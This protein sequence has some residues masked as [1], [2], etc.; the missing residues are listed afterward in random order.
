M[1]MKTSLTRRNLS[2]P[3]LT[4]HFATYFVALTF[5]ISVTILHEM[6]CASLL[7]KQYHQQQD[8]TMDDEGLLLSLHAMN[9]N[10]ELPV[11]S[12][13]NNHNMITRYERYGVIYLKTFITQR[14]NKTLFRRSLY[15]HFVQIKK[16]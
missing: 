8:I 2:F 4:K 3:F 10:N 11:A 9:T 14:Y 12:N 15:F 7:P 16:T 13:P 5:L 1:K 6:E